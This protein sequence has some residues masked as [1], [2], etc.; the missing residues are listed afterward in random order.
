MAA[1]PAVER[2]Q[3]AV[4]V[5]RAVADSELDVVKQGA[6]SVEW[7]GTQH[8]MVVPRPLALLTLKPPPTD[9]TR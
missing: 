8:S 5:G 2:L 7:E 4:F 1:M 9:S 6:L 3:K